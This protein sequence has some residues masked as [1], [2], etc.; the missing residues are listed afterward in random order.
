MKKGGYTL[1]E[2]II[3]LS[4]IALLATVGFSGVKYFKDKSESLKLQNNVYE[5]RALLSFAK[6]YCRKNKVVGNIAINKNKKE[7]VFEVLELNHKLTKIL[8]LDND[9]NVS[10]NFQGGI[11]NINRE[12]F[13]K[14]A[15]TI[16]L[17]YKNNKFIEITVSVG[18][19]IIR[20]NDIDEN[21]GDIID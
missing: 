3:V 15:G 19:D 21:E 11:N 7:V 5:V 6:S 12:G 20:G 13:I 16:S 18:N 1:I 14:T 8:K 9:I 10:S 2:L 17:S 4:I